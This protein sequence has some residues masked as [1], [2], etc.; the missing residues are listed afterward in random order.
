MGFAY[1]IE[2]LSPKIIVI[3]I[4][5]VFRKKVES[6]LEGESIVGRSCFALVITAA[7]TFLSP[8]ISD[9]ITV[10]SLWRTYPRGSS[11][12]NNTV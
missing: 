11:V 3:V 9:S 4:T 7:Q 1:A 2:G 10:A 6:S 8:M 12:D 5:V